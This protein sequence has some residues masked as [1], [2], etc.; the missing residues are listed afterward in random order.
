MEVRGCGGG[1]GVWAICGE[2]CG[3][4]EL[5]RKMWEGEWAMGKCGGCGRGVRKSVKLEV[6]EEARE[7]VWKV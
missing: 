1:A 7:K 2:K 3:G 4:G 6:C 5:W